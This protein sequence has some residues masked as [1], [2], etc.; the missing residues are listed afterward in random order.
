[1]AKFKIEKP[2]LETIGKVIAVAVAGVLA[3]GNEITNQKREAEYK[4]MKQFYETFKNGKE[5]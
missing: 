2:S 5:S 4:E 3:I 1:M